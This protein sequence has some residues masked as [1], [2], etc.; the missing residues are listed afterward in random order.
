MKVAKIT[1]HT[2]EYFINEIY[3]ATE[4]ISHTVTTYAKIKA[5]WDAG[6]LV[7]N[8]EYQRE[9]RASA[10]W[11]SEYITS[12]FQNKV[13][14]C[15]YL[16]LRDDGKFEILDGQQRL[17]TIRDFFENL[18]RIDEVSRDLPKGLVYEEIADR[19]GGAKALRK[20]RNHT[21]PVVIY[22]NIDDI[23]CAEIFVSLN[24][25][26]EMKDMEM[27][28]AVRGEVSKWVREHSRTGWEKQLPVFN[29]I[30]LKSNL[31]M[32][33]DEMI[34]KSFLLEKYHDETPNGI[35]AGYCELGTKTGLGVKQMYEDKEYRFNR[36]RVEQIG[37]RVKSRWS[38]VRRMVKGGRGKLYTG[39]AN[40]MLLRYYT[41]YWLREK[42][43][44]NIS[45]DWD[46]F[47]IAFNESV[48]A[49]HDMRKYGEATRKKTRFHELMSLYSPSERKEMRDLL[50]KEIM[51]RDHGVSVKDSKRT[52][53]P[54][55][56]Y[57]QWAK[58]NFK[59]VICEAQGK[60]TV[61]LSNLDNAHGDHKIP[62]S[63][64]GETTEENLIVLCS[65]HN[66]HKSDRTL[67][68]YCEEFC[69]DLDEM[70]L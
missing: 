44:K 39:Q 17:T 16:R 37:N 62:H 6:L 31:K 29:A 66:N 43:G 20:F 5:M 54:E 64:G 61:R 55:Q 49:L 60:E 48:I 32:N 13:S 11:M 27:L 25:N 21:V 1:E 26:T 36:K 46:K 23:E 22:T 34:A 67:K 7:V 24:N 19:N 70:W 50:F 30:S 10:K 14:S 51:Q 3:E 40:H 9:R 15:V 41:T 38:E 28:N 52:F 65:E 69:I 35:Y 68:E 33:L 18:V 42:F 12:G 58:Q 45:V 59:C 53:T 8:E 4:T 2:Q 63:R 56:K 57:T 47:G